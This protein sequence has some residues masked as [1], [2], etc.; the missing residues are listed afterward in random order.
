[1]EDPS[2]ADERHDRNHLRHRVMPVL[3][4]RW[5]HG[6][7]ALARSASLLATQADLLAAEDARRLALVQGLDPASLSVPA[8]LEQPPAWRDRLL[9]AWVLAQGLPAL[10]GDA[11]AVVHDEVVLARPDS[12]AEYAWSGAVIRRWRDGLF[13]GRPL[14]PLPKDWRVHWDGRAPLALPTGDVLRLEP[15]LGFDAPVLVRTRQGGERIVLPQ[16]G[17]SSELKQVLQDLGIP[18]WQRARLP[19]VFAADGELLAA[20]SVAISAPLQAWLTARGARLRHDLRPRTDP[21]GR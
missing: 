11:L 17:H 8:L 5:P 15:A 13:A 14:P 1:V 9:R 4:A 20:G 7:S 10:P 16:R 6:S 2:N 12:R 18:P 3:S 21:D 19:L